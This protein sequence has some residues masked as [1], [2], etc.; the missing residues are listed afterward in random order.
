MADP[1][2]AGLSVV[3][4]TADQTYP[5]RLVVLRSDTPGKDVAFAEDSL[6]G[7]VHLGVRHGDRLVATSSWIPRPFAADP[8]HAAVQLRGM[9]TLHELQG[10]GLGGMLLNAGLTRARESGAVLVWANARDA[11]LEFYRRHGFRVVG[12]GFVDATTQL[13]HH[14]VV[15]DLLERTSSCILIPPA[16]V[17][18]T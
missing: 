10:T 1:Q 16:D 15:I 11:A 7:T 12:E 5:L 6:P 9:A 18:T 17:H 3:Q 14:V 4:L 2:T 13:P 8:R